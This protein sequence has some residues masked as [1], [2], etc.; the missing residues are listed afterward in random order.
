MQ[1]GSLR[2]GSQ[3]CLRYELSRREPA[4][5]FNT[6]VEPSCRQ[7]LTMIEAALQ[8]LIPIYHAET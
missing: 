2:Y 5:C 1:A 4:S 7:K 6:A 3:E 8:S